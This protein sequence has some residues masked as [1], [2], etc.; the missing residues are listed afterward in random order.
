M[1]ARDALVHLLEMGLVEMVMV[2]GVEKYQIT[3]K[4]LKFVSDS[5]EAGW[6]PPDQHYLST[7]VDTSSTGC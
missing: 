4:G 5:R 6:L 7:I 3:D 1:W 2:D